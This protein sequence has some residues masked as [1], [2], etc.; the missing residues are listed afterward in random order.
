MDQRDADYLLVRYFHDY[1]EALAS[2]L[3]DYFGP[4]HADG[5]SRNA[6]LLAAA[7]APPLP[8][9]QS[10][11]SWAKTQMR[12]FD[13]LSDQDAIVQRF[14]KTFENLEEENVILK[15]VLGQRGKL[16]SAHTTSATTGAKGVDQGFQMSE[17]TIRRIVH[18]PLVRRRQPVDRGTDPPDPIVDSATTLAL[19]HLVATTEA[20]PSSSTESTPRV[21]APA[22]AS[23]LADIRSYNRRVAKRVETAH[24]AVQTDAP[25]IV[26]ISR[27]DGGTQT[28]VPEEVRETQARACQTDV[29]E[30]GQDVASQVD[31]PH[32]AEIKLERCS[33][34]VQSLEAK[35][36]DT[37]HGHEEVLLDLKKVHEGEIC[38][39]RQ[40]HETEKKRLSKDREEM[41][42]WVERSERVKTEA[43]SIQQ[44]LESRCQNFDNQV[45]EMEADYDTLQET[46][47]K[48]TKTHIATQLSHLKARSLLQLLQ[49]VQERHSAATDQAH[50]AHLTTL[51]S[52][53]SA[54][55]V[56]LEETHKSLVSVQ[57]RARRDLETGDQVT[58]RAKQDLAESQKGTQ[59]L[60]DGTL[61]LE[62]LV[63][64]ERE[65]RGEVERCL[66]EVMRFPDVSLGHPV[67]I[68]D[69]DPKDGGGDRI[70]KD[71]ITGN[72]VR[73][74]LLE[75]KNNEL[76]MLRIKLT[77]SN[78]SHM[79]TPIPASSLVDRPAVQKA[80]EA[81][82]LQYLE[83]QRKRLQKHPPKGSMR[84]HHQQPKVP[85]TAWAQLRASVPGHGAVVKRSV[86]KYP[87]EDF[88]LSF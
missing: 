27:K 33:K 63:R 62:R 52:H 71:M 78:P 29:G 50:A 86:T 2:F 3:H 67:G 83:Q 15:D 23:L 12:Y 43:I 81:L 68:E 37:I 13:V 26:E 30:K 57:E 14:L 39:I 85:Y 6:Q 17:V 18:E 5:H 21:D 31:I 61:E 35:L 82:T 9:C 75:Q 11:T 76:R 25:K 41:L 7:P 70:L 38:T 22:L 69:L 66:G 48:L 42:A 49:T 64:V 51:E 45:K 59:K 8:L 87:P 34:K 60:V 4:S 72:S 56:T 53:L 65:R 28:W 1:E 74:S 19:N 46:H 16:T 44:I 40:H 84:E 36:K 58:E 10:I 73:I 24:R 88:H 77:T 55:R 47:D 79:A 20:I 80:T 32:P 54:L